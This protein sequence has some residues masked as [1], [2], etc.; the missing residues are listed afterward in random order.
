M[1]H[2]YIQAAV[3]GL[4]L[5]APLSI[6]QANNAHHEHE[7][8]VA[9]DAGNINFHFTKLIKSS[10]AN[11]SIH[12][13]NAKDNLLELSDGSQWKV[14]KPD[15]VRG[16]EKNEHLVLTQ[17]QATFSTYRFALVNPDLKM[18]IPVSLDREPMP[19]KDKCLFVKEIDKANDLVTLNDN[20][21]WIVHSS[22]TRNLNK[23][24]ENHR[25]IIGVNTG[26]DHERC[27]YILINTTNNNYVRARLI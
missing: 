17:N 4:C 5:L 21:R 26:D 25:I 24:A 7:H 9:T 6:L 16:W 2:K 22:D 11:H 8:V 18:A 12:H 23:M 3:L 15:V 20:G 10:L 1:N 19:A 13:V 27:P 14:S